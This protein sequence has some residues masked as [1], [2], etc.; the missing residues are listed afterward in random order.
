MKRVE[1][2]EK[3]FVK[4]Q[5]KQTNNINC[6]ISLHNK[7]SINKYGLHKWLFDQI[8]ISHYKNVVEVG[9]GVGTLWK[10]NLQKVPDGIQILLSDFSPAM[11]RSCK[12]TL[13]NNSQF[14]YSVIDAQYLPLAS[15]TYDAVIANHMLYHIQNKD[16]VLSEIKRVLRTNG[17]LFASTVGKDNLKELNEIVIGYNPD[18]VWW[19]LT[20][21]FQ[22]EDAPN[23][24]KDYYSTIEVRRYP[25][26]LVVTNYK[27]LI[28]YILSGKGSAVKINHEKFSNYIEKEF[29]KRGGKLSITKD[30]GIIIAS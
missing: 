21:T 3:E 26:A 7:Y 1:L 2:F 5:Y 12:G 4:D 8:E 14:R 13:T 22:L 24:L 15:Q 27:D 23:I 6:R 11:V 30:A 17:R 20:N 9:C 25:D 28:E 19:S 10:N 29:I 18:L 16:A